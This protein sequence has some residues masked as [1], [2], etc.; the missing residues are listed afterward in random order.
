[1]SCD[2]PSPRD[3]TKDLPN[4]PPVPKIDEIHD[5]LKDSKRVHYFIVSCDVTWSCDVVM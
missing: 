5:D 1:M 2:S 4:P 3:L